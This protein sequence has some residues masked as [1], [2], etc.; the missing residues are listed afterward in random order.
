MYAYWAGN[1]PPTQAQLSTQSIS[2]KV[3]WFLAHHSGIQSYIVLHDPF[4]YPTES[5]LNHPRGG[6]QTI[7]VI[8]DVASTDASLG[9]VDK[10]SN[11]FHLTLA[12]YV[13][14][15]DDYTAAM[16]L[17]GPGISEITPVT[18]PVADGWVQL[19][20]H[21]RRCHPLSHK[22]IMPSLML[23][24]GGSAS[25]KTMWEGLAPDILGDAAE[26]AAHC[27]LLDFLKITA[28]R[29]AP[30]AGQAADCPAESQ[31]PF[32]ATFVDDTICYLQVA[33]IKTA[34]LPGLAPIT[35]A[36]AYPQVGGSVPGGISTNMSVI[37]GGSS[38][39]GTHWVPHTRAARHGT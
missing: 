13:P 5:G 21:L 2:S 18:D 11:L 33:Q 20:N 7:W 3:Q 37:T 35:G 32:S 6:N 38:R 10:P 31:L 14:S 16:N 27:S 12:T 29:H 19:S 4:V 9:L 34:C 15:D 36:P 24:Q 28:T 30:P 23:V 26:T 39:S 17:A 1:D 22:Y 8:N 25:H